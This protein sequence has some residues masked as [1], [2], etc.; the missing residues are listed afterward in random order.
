VLAKSAEKASEA[1]RPYLARARVRVR[2]RVRVSDEAVP[3][4]G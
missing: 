1:I 2:V 4:K 3:G